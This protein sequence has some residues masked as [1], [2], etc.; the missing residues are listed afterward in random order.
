MVS[1]TFL[2][3]GV[4]L[5]LFSVF[6]CFSCNGGDDGAV[7]GF[8]IVLVDSGEVV[9]SERHIKAYHGDTHEIEL[10]EEG[11]EKWNSYLTYETI[12]KLDKCLF[13]R[14]FA[15]EIE[16]E[17]VYR[18]KFYSAVSSMSYPGVVIMEALIKLDSSNN[19]IWIDFGYPWPQGSEEDDPRDS[20]VV[21]DFL[22]KRGLLK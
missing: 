1:K 17:E 13:S 12:P 22:E 14:E 19:T 21:I 5:L 8:A 7:P 2:I 6:V 10:N 11:I 15:L 3:T 16:G 4:A 9:L 18:G 20:P